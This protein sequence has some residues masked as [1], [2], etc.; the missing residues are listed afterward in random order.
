MVRR[1]FTILEL[2]VSIGVIAVLMGFL[3]PALSGAKKDAMELAAMAHQREVGALVRQ[4]GFER[5]DTFPYFGITGTNRARLCFSPDDPL[6]F[7][8]RG[9]ARGEGPPCAERDYWD[10]PLYWQIH[11]RFLGY[12]TAFVGLPPELR[13]Q[14]ADKPVI[15][16]TIDIMTFGAYAPPNYFRPGDPQREADLNVQHWVSVEHPSDKIIL[17]RENYV[18]DP[19]GVIGE[20]LS[21]FADGHAEAINQD[22]M[23]PAVPV[24][25]KIFDGWPGVTTLAGLAG[26]DR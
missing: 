21:W 6:G 25:Q 1:A 2:M 20:K 18:R 14:N 15:L 8:S 3:L 22:D 11:M 17:Q 24:R 4:Y 23:G 5:G 26:R 13:A 7:R 19:E 12:D 9:S 16:G 10:Q